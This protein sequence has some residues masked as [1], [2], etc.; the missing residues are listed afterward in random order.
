MEEYAYMIQIAKFL[1]VGL[2]MAI[3]T[4]GPALGLGMIGSK[5]CENM[6]K[7]PESAGAIKAMAFVA[8][9]LVEAL[10]IYI[11]V[12]SLLILFAF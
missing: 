6:G 1:A 3:G 4:L 9:G 10:A 2:A 7:Y 5:V 8:L 11:L 12:V